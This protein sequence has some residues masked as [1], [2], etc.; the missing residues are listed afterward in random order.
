MVCFLLPIA[1]MK[2]ADIRTSRA[3]GHR[4]GFTL[5]EVMIASSIFL[6]VFIAF[7]GAFVTAM[8]HH[9]MASNYTTASLLAKNQ[10]QRAR[11]LD[12][13][14]VSLLSEDGVRVDARGSADLDGEYV[15]STWVLTN[16]IPNCILL[17]VKVWFP[18]RV[19]QTSA[20]PVEIKTILA[21]G[22]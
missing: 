10:I 22:V 3:A 12:F 7:S 13:A 6:V 15:R 5:P 2:C 21:E 8:R 4:A 19:G 9:R 1:A 17:H 11:S 18:T 14:S 16:E 20:A